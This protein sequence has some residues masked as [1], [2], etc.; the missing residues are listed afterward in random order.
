[1]IAAL[2]KIRGSKI[3][4]IG[5]G[6]IGRNLFN[7]FDEYKDAYNFQVKIFSRNTIESIKR[8]RFDYLF[9]CAGNTGDFR[10]NVFQTIESNLFLTNFLLDNV[11]IVKAY[12][13]LSSTRVYGFSEDVNAIFKEDS[14]CSDFNNHLNL[15]F[16]Y[17]GTKKLL[18]AFL[19]NIKEQK[20]FKIIICRV[21]NL[22]G[23][24]E[25]DDLNDSTFIKLMLKHKVNNNSLIIKQSLLSSKGYIFIRDAIEGIILSAIESTEHNIYNIC[26]GR[27]YNLKQWLQYLELNYSINETQPTPLYSKISI[28]KA[29]MELGFTPKYFLENLKFN[30]IIKS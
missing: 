1:M 5:S 26:S 9:N 17:D 18:E 29:K 27:N 24:Y 4:I 14:F 15:D 21:S 19:W 7:Y 10:Q 6:Y 12:V 25:E 30:Q 3:A 28:E 23:G 8:M 16:I 2:N 11:E 13:G 22:Y 20:H